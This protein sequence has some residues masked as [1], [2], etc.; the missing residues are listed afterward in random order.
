MSL[1]KGYLKQL[2]FSVHKPIIASALTKQEMKGFC[3]A[4][5]SREVAFQNALHHL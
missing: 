5:V 4:S 2:L 1:N 3:H